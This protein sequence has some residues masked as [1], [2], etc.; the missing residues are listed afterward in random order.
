M[1]TGRSHH[2]EH[3]YSPMKI[4]LNAIVFELFAQNCILTLC[5]I[6]SNSGHVF[7]LEAV[8][9]ITLEADIPRML[10]TKF[11][12]ILFSSFKGE[13]F[14]KKVFTD[15]DDDGRQVMTKAHMAFGQVS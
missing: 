8:S 1:P 3:F 6:F 14:F 2:A 4:L 12:Q 5:S 10:L 9:D 15:D 11:H 7:W 13:D